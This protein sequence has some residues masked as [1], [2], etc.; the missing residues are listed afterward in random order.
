MKWRKRPEVVMGAKYIGSLSSFCV[1][2]HRRAL[3]LLQELLGELEALAT[4]VGLDRYPQLERAFEPV[5]PIGMLHQPYDRARVDLVLLLEQRITALRRRD[6]VGGFRSR[7][8]L[9]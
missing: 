7:A 4:F 6:R 1:G 9:V 8:P 5:I 2:L 3:E